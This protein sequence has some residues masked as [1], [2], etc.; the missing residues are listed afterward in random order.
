MANMLQLILKNISQKPRTRLYPLV[1]REPFER[2]R[3]QIEMKDE[4]CIY[5]N[6]CARKCP[7]DAI[8]VDRANTTWTLN[9]YRCII[10][11]ECVSSCPK[12]C[13]TM[14]SERRSAGPKPVTVTHVKAAEAKAE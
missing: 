11:N 14:K 12:K 1:K 5:C 13:I 3:G 8:T 4:N 9:A 6:I 10:C 2:S 7:A